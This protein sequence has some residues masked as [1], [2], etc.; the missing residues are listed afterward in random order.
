[1]K[2]SLLL[3]S[4]SLA[5]IP[6]AT[7]SLLDQPSGTVTLPSST[8]P[9]AAAPGVSPT[10]NVLNYTWS[11]PANPA[12]HGTYT[13]SGVSTSSFLSF[14]F[15]GV[16]SGY[17]P[18]NTYLRMS[19]IDSNEGWTLAAWDDQGNPVTTAWLM[20]AIYLGGA[21]PAAFVQGFMP[22]YT[23]D[24][25]TGI[26]QF[27]GESASGN[28]TLLYVLQTSENLSR[29]DLTRNNVSN[30]ISFAAPDVPEP[31]TWAMLGAGLVAAGL[32]R[33]RRRLS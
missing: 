29:I 15:T 6:A 7:A 13:A 24:A 16:G 8:G 10:N 5:C 26:Y 23:F 11:A 25:L 4:L 14:D 2:H 3:F 22:S 9:S 21:D 18:S 12:W 19:D 17:I 32:A 1:M 27:T 33:R 31:G 30:S 20:D 28:P